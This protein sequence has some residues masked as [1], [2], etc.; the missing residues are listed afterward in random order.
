[1]D[2][3]LLL[4]KSATLLYRESLIQG[5]TDNSSELVRTVIESIKL[6]DVN[7]GVNHDRDIL[8]ALKQTALEMCANPQD[9]I[10][11]KEDLLQRLKLN[12]GEDEK[13]YEAFVQGID[14]DLNESSLKRTV[15]NIRKTINNHFRE[16]KIEELLSK[17]SY[18]FKHARDKIRNVNQW[19]SE[20]VGQ[21]EPFQLDTTSKDPAIISEIDTRNTK[22]VVGVFDSI[23]DASSG[24]SILQSGWQAINRM[25]QGGFRRGEQWVIGALQHKWKTGFSLSLFMQFALFNVPVMKDPTKKPLLLRISFEDTLKLNFQFLYQALKE[26]ETGECPNINGLSS[27]E[28]AEYVQK[29][30]AVNGYH[31]YFM[32]VNPSLWTY[33]DI[34]NKVIELEADGYEVHLCMLDYLL[35]VPTT[36]CDQGAMGHDIRNMYE[37]TRNFMNAKDILMITPHQLASSAKMRVRDGMPDFVKSL[38]GEGHYAGCTQLDQVVDGEL[39]IHIEIEGKVSYLTV[40]RGKHRIIEQTPPKDL[41][42]VLKFGKVCILNDVGKADSSRRKV[43]HGPVSSDDAVPFWDVSPV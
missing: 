7:I 2:T 25:L 41:Y 18:T 40:Q 8:A 42:T 5:K 11:E 10:Y 16:Q 30:L 20:V 14:P 35:K 38:V 24:I 4:V 3:K 15:V 37:R 17:A 21:L 27:E 36:G 32:H 31:T 39:F 33:K 23:K 22:D 34:C 1:M 28:M 13:L 29:A 19:V 12:T 26:N 43:G 9:H 6:T